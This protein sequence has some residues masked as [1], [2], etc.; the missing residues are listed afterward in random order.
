MKMKVA[1]FLLIAFLFG[2]SPTLIN[3][4]LNI[5][6]IQEST[7]N[8]V[9]KNGSLDQQI[10]LIEFG[11]GGTSHIHM[12]NLQPTIEIA[13]GNLI[14]EKLISHKSLASFSRIE[15]TIEKL[16][17]KNKVGTAKN[18]EI[19]CEIESNLHVPPIS[20]DKK[21]QTFSKNIENMSPFIATAANIIL[22][23]CL[24]QHASK[25]VDM[26]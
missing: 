21:V 23:Q 15:V 14:K 12:L 2:C 3:V 8:V 17:L 10:Y 5:P 18:D 26:L 6:I 22:M 4:P 13:L 24:Q 20:S 19:L 7:I 11:F 9:V 25:I 16:E 1:L